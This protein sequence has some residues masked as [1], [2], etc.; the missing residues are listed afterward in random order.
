ME[1]EQELSRRV[2]PIRQ[3]KIAALHQEFN[4]VPTANGALRNTFLVLVCR[5]MGMYTLDAD[6]SMAFFRVFA[7]D[8]DAFFVLFL[9]L[10]C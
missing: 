1:H 8:L 4:V 2:G 10:A 9:F 3:R 6:S 5:L 7:S